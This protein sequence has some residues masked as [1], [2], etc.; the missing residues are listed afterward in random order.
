MFTQ[1][2]FALTSTQVFSWTDLVTDSEQFYNS[3]LELLED[4]D[5]KDEVDQLMEWWNRYVLLGI[6][7]NEIKELT[8]RSFLYILKMNDCLPRIVFWQEFARNKLRRLVQLLL[9]MNSCYTEP[10]LPSHN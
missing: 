4:P 6:F 9:E 10:V 2:H 1:A 3:I 5:E 8:D 7:E